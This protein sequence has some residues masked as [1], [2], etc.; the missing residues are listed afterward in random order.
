MARYGPLSDTSALR[1]SFDNS[2]RI[3]IY[4]FKCKLRTVIFHPQQ[5]LHPSSIKTLGWQFQVENVVRQNGGV[6]VSNSNSF[7]AK[8]NSNY[9]APQVPPSEAN[10]TNFTGYGGGMGRYPG[11][12]QIENL[13]KAEYPSGLYDQS[14]YNGGGL[15]RTDNVPGISDFQARMSSFGFAGNPSLDHAAAAQYAVAA[16]NGYDM[17]KGRFPYNML[18]DADFSWPALKNVDT[19]IKV[20]L[21][22]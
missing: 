12:P 21:I 18:V 16:Q 4:S 10:L 8:Y 15:G 22:F 3:F 9:A 17:Y 2:E 19:H 7:E 20:T 14:L 11:Y 6:P 13:A 1:S 5:C